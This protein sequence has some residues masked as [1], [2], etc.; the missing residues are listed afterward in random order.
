MFI[1]SS[2]AELGG[3]CFSSIAQRYPIK[4]LLIL[5]LGS[6]GIMC[7]AVAVIPKQADSYLYT[8][9]IMI[10]A[11]LGK[12]LAS[13]AF[14]LIYVYASQLFPTIVR[15]TLLAYVACAGRIGSLIAPQIN[16]LGFMVWENLPYLIFSSNSFLACSCIFWLPDLVEFVKPTF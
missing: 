13:A 14:N 12:A 7:M 9:M 1:L 3:Y 6:S 5:T 8:S 11:S 16:L 2:F 10:F 4:R 15:N